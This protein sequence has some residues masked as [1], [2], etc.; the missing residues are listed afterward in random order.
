MEKERQ[1]TT[2]I[3]VS[4]KESIK[5]K[6]YKTPSNYNFN[7]ECGKNF[8]LK[9][10]FN[11]HRKKE[12]KETQSTPDNIV[13][14]PNYKHCPL[15]DFSA[16]F[17]DEMIKHLEVIHNILFIEETHTFSSQADFLLWKRRKESDT[18]SKFINKGTQ[19]FS[20]YKI[21]YFDCHR[22]GFYIAKGKGSRSLKTQGSVKINS[23][24]P[25]RIKLKCFKHDGKCII[26]FSN[27]HV[28]HINES[29][30]LTLTLAEREDLAKKIALKIP[31]DDILDQVRD[32][33]YDCSLQ[34]IHL[35][36]RKD[37]YNIETA[38]SLQ[39]KAVRH[40]DDAISVDAWVKEIENEGNFIG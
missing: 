38:Y 17:R 33:V 16:K 2:V 14:N 19:T 6:S 26:Y 24:C 1:L 40:K 5:R 39:S 11:A 25:S 3:Q 18:N 15:C 28:G 22:S 12:H 29:K 13:K 20:K 23:F 31:F 35:L 9:K 10:H 4:Q 34:R 27:T 7:C 32:S 36:S 30:Y 37:L 8:T 21:T